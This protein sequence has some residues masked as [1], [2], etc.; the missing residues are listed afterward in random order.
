MDD[1]ERSDSDNQVEALKK[2]LLDTPVE[3]VLVNHCYGI[4]ELAAMYLSESP[5]LLRPA[6]LAID[7]LG[8][9]VDG[10]PGRLGESERQ[11]KDGLSQLRIAYVQIDGAQRA[12]ERVVAESGTNGASGVAAPAETTESSSTNDASETGAGAEPTE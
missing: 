3:V 9:L 10:L 4:F 5:P 6:C 1:V 12:G 7:A 8:C 11:L 2:E